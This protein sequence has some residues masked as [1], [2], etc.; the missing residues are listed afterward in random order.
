MAE[1]VGAQGLR[2]E[3]DCHVQGREEAMGWGRVS[4]GPSTGDEVGKV[5]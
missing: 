1:T 2:Q 3:H 5:I 4:K